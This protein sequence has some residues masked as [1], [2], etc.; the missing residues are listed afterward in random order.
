[1]LRKYSVVHGFL[2]GIKLLVLHVAG[3]ENL[4][5]KAVELFLF[6]CFIMSAGLGLIAF[7]VFLAF[8][9]GLSIGILSVAGILIIVLTLIV[10]L[11]LAIRKAKGQQAIREITKTLAEGN[12]GGEMPA[13]K[14]LIV[15]QQI[16]NNIE[17]LS[18]GLQKA[19]EQSIYDER[20]KAELITNVSHDI[21]TPLTSII[22]YVD[23]MKRESI[24]NEK[25]LHYIE[26]LDQKSH[27]LKQLTEDLVEVSKISS[28]NIEL[29]CMPI[30]F[31]E[32][33][34]QSIGEFEDKFAEHE[35]QIIES[36][37]KEACMVYA[38]GRRTFRVMD[39]L[40]QNIY[41][42]AM[43]QTRV[44]IDLVKSGG[45]IQLSIKNISKAE[46]NIDARELMERF[47]RGDQSRTTEG[48]GLGLSIAGDLIRIQGGRFDIQLDGD[49]FKVIIV[50]QEY[51]EEEEQNSH[52]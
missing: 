10:I 29:E 24:E 28:G 19:V 42:Y 27:R 46:L 14:T 26:V 20:M 44:Y 6:Y 11:V 37:S 22:N 25:V 34:R 16:L 51:V 32:L 31:G 48:S 43:P 49:L 15:E 23:L 13:P 3:Q 21:K 8:T 5:L 1:M 45:E 30:D 40:L 2:Y 41:K 18:D 38:D 9:T 33:V 52:H 35:L 7:D 12:L 39:N 17:H 50:F 4:V 36:I 47:V